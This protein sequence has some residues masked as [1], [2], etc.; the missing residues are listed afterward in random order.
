MVTEWGMSPELKNVYFGGEQEVFIG[1]DYQTQASYSDEVAAIIDQEIRKIVDNA[2]DR[3]LTTIKENE[4]KLHVMVALLFQHETIYGDE[5]D[6]IMEGKSAEE[7]SA[8]IEEKKAKREAEAKAKAEE[9]KAKENP[10]GN[11][12]DFIVAEEPVITITEPIILE[13]K[14]EETKEEPTPESPI[15]KPKDEPTDNNDNE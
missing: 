5:V 7:I 15:E 4:D 12:K 13:G 10:L 9:A 1:R 3:A 2:Y 8:F 6:M 11:P 14:V